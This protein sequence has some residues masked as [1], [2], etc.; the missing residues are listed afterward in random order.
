MEIKPAE[1]DDAGNRDLWNHHLQIDLFDASGTWKEVLIPLERAADNNFGF[2]LQTGGG[3]G[4]LQWDKIK[5]FE[6]TC[7]YTTSGGTVNTPIATGVILV[8]KLELV[9]NRYNP[10]QTFDN[11]ATDVFST[12]YMSWAGTGASSIAFSNNT[13]DFVEGTGSL[14]MDYTVNASQ[15][16]GGYLNLADTTWAFP[17]S[18]SNRT[19]L[20]LYVK[21]V[22]P[23]VGTTP[24]RV[25]MRFFLMEN[26]TGANEDWV[27]E[28]PINFE[29]AGEWTRYYLPLK[30][31]TV[32]TDSAGK[33]RFPQNGFAQPW[34][35]ITGD[36]TFNPGSV[37]G[38]KIE[39]SAGGDDYGPVGETFTGQLLF[40]VLAAIRL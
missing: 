1:F 34:W 30:Q 4:E 29:E 40:D 10:F 18:F 19:A 38:W 9:G 22:V 2:S 33:S 8:D 5:G 26:S 21:N 27:I 24:K 20:V 35:S 7:V 3:D 39:L 15:S 17:D 37:T 11:A 28:V 25:T 31:D 14:Q 12:D 32:W 16:W 23:F 6:L 13:T 36:N